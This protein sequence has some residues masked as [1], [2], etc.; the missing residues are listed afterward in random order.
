[1]RCQSLVRVL[2]AWFTIP[3]RNKLYISF[4]TCIER[5]FINVRVAVCRKEVGHIPLQGTKILQSRKCSL[6][7]ACSYCFVTSKRNMRILC[8]LYLIVKANFG[9]FVYISGICLL[10]SCCYKYQAPIVCFS[11]LL[12]TE[13]SGG[14]REGWVVQEHFLLM[15]RTWVCCPEMNDSS[16]LIYS[17]SSTT[18]D[19]ASFRPL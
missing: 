9:N 8:F 14:R 11:Q 5:S 1:M 12:N 18:P 3:K 15:E 16:Q 17:S 2:G 19:A 6:F 13:V 7:V 10:F 4:W